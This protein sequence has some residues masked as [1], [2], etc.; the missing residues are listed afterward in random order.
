MEGEKITF[1]PGRGEGLAAA[2][3]SELSQVAFTSS[4]PALFISYVFTTLYN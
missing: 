4:K 1:L 3:K 2:D